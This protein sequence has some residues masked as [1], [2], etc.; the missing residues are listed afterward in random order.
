MKRARIHLSKL[1]AFAGSE[2]P[3][4]VELPPGYHVDDHGA[5]WMGE[6]KTTNASAEAEGDH[7]SKGNERR[8]PELI[9]SSPIAIAR[10]VVHVVDKD[11]RAEIVFKRAG[12][13]TRRLVDR[14]DAVRSMPLVEALASYGA[15][16]A[17]WNS[18]KLAAYLSHFDS[19]NDGRLQRV[20]CVTRCGHYDVNGTRFFA[21]GRT[22]IGR[23][24]VD[25]D[26]RAG[27]GPIVDALTVGG[28]ERAQL[29][30]LREACGSD[31]LA[32]LM[33]FGA[34]AAPLLH[35]TGSPLFG[36]QLWGE[37][38]RGKSTKLVVAAGIYGNPSSKSYVGTWEATGVGLEQR[39]SALCDLPMAIDESTGTDAKARQSAAYNLMNGAGRTRGAQGGGMRPTATWRTV[40][41]S[42]GESPLVD[43][44]GN[45]GAQ[46]RVA[47]FRNT[48]FGRLDGE[49]VAAIEQRARQNYGHVGVAWVRYLLKL[50]RSSLRAEL[51]T[52]ATRARELAG[53][54]PIAQR[55]AAFFAVMALAESHAHRLLGIGT[56]DGSTVLDLLRTGAADHV[57]PMAERSLAAVRDWIES[58]PKAFPRR[59][60]PVDHLHKVNGYRSDDAYDLIGSELDK[61]LKIQNIDPT[62]AR[63]AWNERGWL[64][65]GAE[66]NRLTRKARIGG[67]PGNYVAIRLDVLE[68][69]G[70]PNPAGNDAESGT[71]PG[72]VNRNDNG[73]LDDSSHRSHRSHRQTM[74]PDF[75]QD[76]GTE[77]DARA[78][79]DRLSGNNGNNGNR[80][81]IDEESG[82][83]VV[84]GSVPNTGRAVTPAAPSR[85]RELIF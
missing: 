80:L 49:Q 76:D 53:K 37:S 26:D 58:E 5:L 81:I 85:P 34:L 68:A 51:H 84:P 74:T 12:K 21:L 15:P 46:V 55:R 19:W 82:P 13:W 73:T 42:T 67:N 78:K 7:E 29:E 16:V 31:P 36:I 54:D 50:D 2:I 1:P 56:A 28:D 24:S 40:V 72:T 57:Q 10:V 39:A 66:P 44:H 33:V 38:S 3:A 63:K 83:S 23:P 30:N 59:A 45:T 79:V 6:P 65:V 70:S 69:D 62:A 17:G 27:V 60:E 75:A 77:A 43:E 11:E 25:F 9:A 8:R 52:Y 48:G 18:T 41:L 71:S 47:S 61:R 4:D 20:P 32:S 14:K 64:I 35:L 22:C